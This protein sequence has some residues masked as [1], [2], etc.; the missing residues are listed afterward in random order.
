VLPSISGMLVHLRAGVRGGGGGDG[1]GGG[2]GG[3]DCCRDKPCKPGT[4]VDS[5]SA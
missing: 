3:G 1:G 5:Q 2:G 4:F